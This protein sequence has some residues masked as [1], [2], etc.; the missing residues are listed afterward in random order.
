MNKQKPKQVYFF[1]IQLIS[2]EKYSETTSTSL[3]CSRHKQERMQFAN[4]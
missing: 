3:E 1:Q 4:K 2:A